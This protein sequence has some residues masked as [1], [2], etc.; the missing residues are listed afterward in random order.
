[1]SNTTTAPTP[2]I[3]EIITRWLADA[4]VFERHGNLHDAGM[5]QRCAVTM[6]EATDEEYS[7]WFSIPA[8][9]SR[10]GLRPNQMLRL[11]QRYRNTPHVRGRGQTLQL[12]ACIVPVREREDLAPSARALA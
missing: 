2:E 11:A 3:S 1:M 12:R 10:S 7:T 8:A 9:C 5:L 4:S 6:A